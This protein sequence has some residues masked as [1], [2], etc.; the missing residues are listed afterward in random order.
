MWKTAGQGGY[1]TQLNASSVHLLAKHVTFLELV[2]N[3]IRLS[4]MSPAQAAVASV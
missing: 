4:P 3:G 2:C 1:T